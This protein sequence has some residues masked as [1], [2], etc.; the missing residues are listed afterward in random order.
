MA[1]GAVDSV[2]IFTGGNVWGGADK[3]KKSAEIENCTSGEDET[4][5][6]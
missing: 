5:T 6:V 4:E 1:V 3:P 2:S